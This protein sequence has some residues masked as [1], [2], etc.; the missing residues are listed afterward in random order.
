MHPLLA[1]LINPY[2]NNRLHAAASYTGEIEGYTTLRGTLGALLTKG[3]SLFIE[4]GAGPTPKHH[5]AEARS[6]ALLVSTIR[7]SNPSFSIGVLSPWRAQNR[8]IILE[9]EALGI[10]HVGDSHDSVKV[11]TIE[12]FQGA[13]RDVILLSTALSEARYLRAMQSIIGREGLPAPYENVDRKLVV[14]LSR[15]RHQV[16]I[17]GHAPFLSP[18]PHF[19]A[20]LE[21]IRKRQGF[22]SRQEFESAISTQ[23]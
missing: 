11:D 8:Q 4:T 19:G 3:R 13:E 18:D 6:I 20:I 22:I 23:G 21:V 5:Q 15:A 10:T 2:Y 17:L 16:I 1:D 14:A 12:R 7:R 9:L